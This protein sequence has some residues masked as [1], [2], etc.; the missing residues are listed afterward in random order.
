MV[1]R[2]MKDILSSM[3]YIWSIQGYFKLPDYIVWSYAYALIM[4]SPGD[5]LRP[6]ILN[7]T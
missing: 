2:S 5:N 3:W 4:E 7:A 1:E 6:S